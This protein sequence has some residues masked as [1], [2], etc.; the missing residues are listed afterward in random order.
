MSKNS[1]KILIHKYAL[2]I[3]LT[4]LLA[5]VGL[6]SGCEEKPLP[7]EVIG[8]PVFNFEGELGSANVH[9]QAGVDDYYMFSDYQKD[10]QDVHIFTGEFS[11]LACEGC[12]ESLRIGI[13]DFRKVAT[14]GEI[15]ILQALQEKTYSFRYEEQQIDI[16]RVF[17]THQGNPSN[18]FNWDFGDGSTSSDA[19]PVHEYPDSL[20]AAQV[21]LQSTDPSGCTTNIC[22][23]INLADTTCKADFIHELDPQR[24]YVRFQ[25]V[26]SGKPP[27][28]Y[29]WNFGD[30]FGASLGNPGYFYRT[31]GRYRVCLTITDA[32]QCTNTICK[33]ITADPALCENNFTYEVQ[34]SSTPDPLQLSTVIVRWR[35]ANGTVFRSDYQEQPSTS[36]FRILSSSLYDR[37]EKG[38]KT[39]MVELE[40][41]CLLFAENGE[42]MEL[43]NGKAV[44]A[45]AY[46]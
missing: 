43:K 19:N 17:F 33:N 8:E 31:P 25:A 24:S 41:N 29:R 45:V 22:N 15:D 46:P 9:L 14:G 30:G 27:L 10:N 5:S 18:S 12:P 4:M 42:K 34:R 38:E 13:R 23:Q 36:S 37:N 32:N 11:P 1:H 20:N 26:A 21:C 39:A 7:E 3:V 6:S 28:R 44:I 35:D 2:Q 16:F 40:V